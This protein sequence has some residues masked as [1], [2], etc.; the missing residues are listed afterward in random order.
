MERNI[1]CHAIITKVNLIL[2]Q[3]LELRWPINYPELKKG[4]RPFK[5]HIDWSLDRICSEGGDMGL[6]E[7]VHSEDRNFQEGLKQD[8]SAVTL[9]V[10]E[11]ALQACRT[12]RSEWCTTVWT[13]VSPCMVVSTHFSDTFGSSFSRIHTVSLK[14]GTDRK[15]VSGMIY[16]HLELQLNL[17]PEQLYI[18][19]VFNNPCLI[20]TTFS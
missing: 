2:Q 19:S 15:M 1:E 20:P 14:L 5:M 9:S 17:M 4:P 11:W 7:L 18:I 8:L 10:E 3:S 16:S 13:T 12:R 6:G